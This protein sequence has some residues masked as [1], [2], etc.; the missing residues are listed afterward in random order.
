[1]LPK[2]LAQFEGDRVT[3]VASER[4]LCVFDSPLPIEALVPVQKP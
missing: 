3:G 4:G 2:L 1:M